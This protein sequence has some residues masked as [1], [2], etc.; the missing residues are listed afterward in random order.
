MFSMG[1]SRQP[2]WSPRVHPMTPLPCPA[3]ALQRGQGREA[4]S[5]FFPRQVL[6]R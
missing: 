3:R 1:R 5:A 4:R 6:G 2:K